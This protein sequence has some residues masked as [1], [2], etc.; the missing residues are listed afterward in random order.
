MT[1]R[2]YWNNMA[3]T[4]V[5]GGALAQATGWNQGAG[6]TS[7][8]A[9]SQNLGGDETYT[10]E[11]YTKDLSMHTMCFSN[12][13]ARIATNTLSTAATTFRFRKNGA[14]GNSTVSFAAGVTGIV[15]DVAN[16]DS[17]VS[18]DTYNASTVTDAGGTGVCNPSYVGATVESE[19]SHLNF[20]GQYNEV[21]NLTTASTTEYIP[22]SGVMV[23]GVT[24][25]N[26][27]KAQIDYACT[28]H[29]L[30]VNV[31]ANGRGTATTFRSRVNNANGNQ[32]VSFGAGVTGQAQDASNL[33]TLA[34]GDD[35]NLSVTTGTG[36]GTITPAYTATHSMHSAAESNFYSS[37]ASGIARAASATRH[38]I[39]LIGSVA[40]GG[41]LE[42]TETKAQVQINIAGTFSK[43]KI[44]LSANTY[45]ATATYNFRKNGSNG[46]QTISI[47]AGAT[48]LL[49]DTTN[50]DTV[51]ASDS[52]VHSIV[53][54]TSGSATVQ[55]CGALFT[56]AAKARTGIIRVL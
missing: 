46:N 36:T 43:A 42:T 56:N 30:T 54:G 4:F 18:G 26:N 40:A 53:D 47:T 34:A 16:T 39:R 27:V 49:E 52:V 50:S 25:E 9:L 14:N 33:D 28:W 8:C 2:S 10:T 24:T 13:T 19:G 41:V 6:V 38:F 11:N 3:K 15:T 21:Y 17:I 5:G 23:A 48:G 45:S 29:G 37:R 20:F 31:A 44:Y 51:V 35:V 32:T 22:V 12:F 7:F 55:W 1:Q